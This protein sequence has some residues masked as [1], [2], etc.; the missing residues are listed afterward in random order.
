M[1]KLN[2]DFTLQPFHKVKPVSS[3]LSHNT[4]FLWVLFV[5]ISVF[6]LMMKPS[7]NNAYF[8]YINQTSDYFNPELL[9]SITDMGN[10]IVTGSI[11]VL[12]LCFKPTWILRVL[13]AAIICL[14][15]T[16]LLKS[17]FAE[18]RPAAILEQINII[19]DAR[20]SK[21]FPSGHTATI[22]LLAGTAFLSS[23]R[24]LS[25]IVFV[26][27]AVIVGLS[28]IAVGAHWP[29]DIALGAIIGWSSIY[30]A[31]ILCKP[32]L[33]DKQLQLIILTTLLVLLAI[34]S[35][36]STTEFAQFPIVE[37]LQQFYLLAAT[38]GLCLYQRSSRRHPSSRASSH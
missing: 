3:P 31:S 25:R 13:L 9:A 38:F 20:Y 19:G 21:S 8:W 18:L 32:S 26:S 24:L 2:Q 6:L 28:R 34:L 30:L 10:G 27:L 29:I 4:A 23:T 36:T 14:I 17:Y 11:M 33:L 37:R 16:H 12:I 15:S 22:F 7:V 1:N 5:L 35:I